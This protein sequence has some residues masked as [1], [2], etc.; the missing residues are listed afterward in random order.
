MPAGPVGLLLLRRT[1]AAGGGP[2]VGIRSVEAD[3]QAEMV[4]GDPQAG[5]QV[6]V[7]PVGRGRADHDPAD[8]VIQQSFLPGVD[9]HPGS[10]PETVE[11]HLTASLPGSPGSPSTAAP[12]APAA[13][14]P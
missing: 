1:P 9:A 10:D 13:R 14:S 7:H 3:R 6:F 11:P 12:A 4:H 5:P 2:P 8:L